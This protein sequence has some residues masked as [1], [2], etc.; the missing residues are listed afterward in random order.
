MCGADRLVLVVN[1]ECLR[2]SAL[3]GGKS[4]AFVLQISLQLPAEMAGLQNVDYLLMFFPQFC[5]LVV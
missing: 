3:R 4:W 2:D 1:D 5:W